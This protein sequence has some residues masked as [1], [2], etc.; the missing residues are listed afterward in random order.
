MAENQNSSTSPLVRVLRDFANPNSR[1][2]AADLVYKTLMPDPKV[3]KP[4]GCVNGSYVQSE[5]DGFVINPLA[6]A[7]FAISN[8]QQR[9]NPLT[10]NFDENGL[11]NGAPGVTNKN[12]INA[13]P[14]AGWMLRVERG[15]L[16]KA[17]FTINAGVPTVGSSYGVSLVADVAVMKSR[18]FVP[19][20]IGA[21]NVISTPGAPA[22]A[23]ANS[24]TT[25]GAT[26]GDEYPTWQLAP[27]D[28]QLTGNN[29][30]VE[31]WPVA[32]DML[33]NDIVLTALMEDVDDLLTY[34]CK[35]WFF[36]AL[37]DGS[38]T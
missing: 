23:G 36:K 22:V 33:F 34:I 1:E 4:V 26:A 18:Y 19:N 30:K 14:I 21:D 10:F 28:L 17:P 31:V 13:A 6:Y 11:I 16:L 2:A 12:V 35:D 27:A 5:A 38:N 29:A 25:Y 8:K 37:G 32:N 3:V 20:P 15:D 7:A 24:D 9:I